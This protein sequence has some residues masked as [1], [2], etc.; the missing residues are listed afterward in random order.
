MPINFRTQ[1]I[2]QKFAPE[3]DFFFEAF[4]TDLTTADF[5]LDGQLDIV[6]NSNQ[7]YLGDGTGKFKPAETGNTTSSRVF[8]DLTTA[9]VNQDGKPDLCGIIGNRVAIRLGD[10]TGKLAAPRTFTAGIG[11]NALLM[12]DVN[13]DKRL[14]A[15]T[16]NFGQSGQRATQGLFVHLGDGTGN[17]AAPTRK[18]VIGR[19]INIV[20][21]D[22]NG[23]GRFDL[24][25]VSDPGTDKRPNVRSKNRSLTVLLGDGTG[26]FKSIQPIELVDQTEEIAAADFNN[27]GKTDVVVGSDEQFRVLLGSH[28]GEL[29]LRNQFSTG[30]SFYERPFFNSVTPVDV[31]GD[32]NLDFATGY[33]GTDSPGYTIIYVSLGNGSGDFSRFAA[34]DTA[35][36]NSRSDESNAYD[37]VG[38]DFNGDGKF[39]V[40]TADGASY[41][42]STVTVFLSQNSDQIVLTQDGVDASM[43]E[44]AA[45]AVR[46]KDRT[47]KLS[48]QS[49]LIEVTGT[50]VIG[51]VRPDQISG[52]RQDNFLNGL[53]GDDQLAG[54]KGDDRLVGGAGNDQMQGGRGKD[55]FVFSATPNYPA[56]LN[57]VFSQDAIGVDEITDFQPGIDKIVLDAGTFTALNS[58]ISFAT[59]S[60][61]EAAQTSRA[62]LTYVSSRGALYYNANGSQSGFGS[63]G[64][65]A[66]LKGGVALSAEDFLIFR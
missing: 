18:Q 39:D 24:A 55:R 66:D 12:A 6:T 28:K 47:L 37:V 34:F 52:D 19:P 1:Q 32:G 61:P 59:V 48:T 51:T 65:F 8:H 27:D 45:I 46:L 13:G 42:E 3:D 2:I 38:G 54:L 62:L 36:S 33:N 40:A 53:G 20:N 17:F 49:K 16:A 26:Q 63:G 4:P 15:I 58:N 9:D 35:V 60:S 44:K 10:G 31:N 57:R 29:K 7:L 64:Q 21:G 30:G 5:N 25:V 41:Y 23:D 11:L 56:G 22:F 43:V 50:D 14:D